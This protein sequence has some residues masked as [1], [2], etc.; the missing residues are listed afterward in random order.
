VFKQVINETR[1]Q[2]GESKFGIHERKHPDWCVMSEES[3]EGRVRHITRRKKNFPAATK[4]SIRS[5]QDP[6]LEEQH[7]E[8]IRQHAKGSSVYWMLPLLKRARSIVFNSYPTRYIA[9]PYIKL[10]FVSKRR[11]N[12]AQTSC[13]TWLNLGILTDNLVKTE[14]CYRMLFVEQ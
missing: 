1:E 3:L 7:L 12:A 2:S 5:L 6:L 4:A 11:R 9:R 14:I 8:I 10:N 13:V